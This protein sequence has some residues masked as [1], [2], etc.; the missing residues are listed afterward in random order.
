MNLKKG[1]SNGNRLT[2][3]SRERA[4][5]GRVH[6]GGMS[7]SGA[8]SKGRNNGRAALRLDNAWRAVGVRSGASMMRL[9]THI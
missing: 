6:R 8:A 4:S 1:L 9:D 2:F 7:R 5:G 3:S